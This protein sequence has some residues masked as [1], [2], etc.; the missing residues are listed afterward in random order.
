MQKIYNDLT[1]YIKEHD[2]V[3]IMGHKNIDLDA[4]GSAVAFY[5]IIKQ[6]KKNV[7][8]YITKKEEN[9]SIINA[10][11]MLDTI[12]IKI[13]YINSNTYKE[14]LSTNTLLLILDTHKI[15]LIENS[16]LVEEVKTVLICDHHIKHDKSPFKVDYEYINEKISSMNEFAIGYLKYLNIKIS[17]M[18]ATIMLA[19]MVIDTNGFNSKTSNETYNAASYLKTMGADDTLKQQLLQERKEVLVQRQRLLS[20]S[21]NVLEKFEVCI[22]DG[23]VYEKMDLAIIA[24]ELLKFEG[25][26]AS[27]CIA[28]TSSNYVSISARSLGEID[29]E[30]IMTTLGGGGHKNIAAATLKNK[31]INEVKL[32]LIE[33]LGRI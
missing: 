20:K 16:D 6:F 18:L 11:K 12:P 24:D 27:F 5:K 7:Y 26:K 8:I 19:G 22:L 2:T 23:K 33:L 17:S 10:Y 32:S 25:V 30:K 29:V 4:L 13:N 3:I 14:K 9:T 1:K 15:E 21:E 31:E 28:K